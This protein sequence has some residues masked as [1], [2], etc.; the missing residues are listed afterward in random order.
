LLWVGCTMGDSHTPALQAARLH[1]GAPLRARIVPRRPSDPPGRD[2]DDAEVRGMDTHTAALAASAWPTSTSAPLLAAGAVPV[3]VPVP[4]AVPASAHAAA[5]ERQCRVC[6]GGVAEESELGRLFSPCRCKGTMK[7]VHVQCLDQW[8]QA[9]ARRES[10]IRCDQCRYEYNLQRTRLAA[11]LTHWGA[12]PHPHR[13]LCPQ[14]TH[15]HCH[16]IERVHG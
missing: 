3:P 7:Y 15:I 6:L 12:H 1:G 2:P 11:L 13:A 14:T 5:S 16:T 4:A 9:S 8:R 10:F